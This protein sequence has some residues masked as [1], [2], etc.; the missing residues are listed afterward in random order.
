MFIAFKDRP[1]S[2]LSRLPP[3][4]TFEPPCRTFRTLYERCCLRMHRRK[5][6]RWEEE[7]GRE[8]LANDS[9][10]LSSRVATLLN[11]A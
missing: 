8:K 5:E 7:E 1:G 11:A 3:I 9:V 4:K 10:L 2:P 6:A